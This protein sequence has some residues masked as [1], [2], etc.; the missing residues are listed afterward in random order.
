MTIDG[1]TLSHASLETI[2]LMAVKRVRE[3][4]RPS[5]VI[6]SYGLCRTSVYRWLRAEKRS[7]EGA[8]KSRKGTGR[9]C[10]LTKRN[11]ACGGGYAER[12]RVNTA[13][14]SGCGHGKLSAL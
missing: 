5:A 4:E 3:G 9:P 1:R 7:G 8:L 13:L 14:I 2:R 10:T 6:K 12:T 11:N